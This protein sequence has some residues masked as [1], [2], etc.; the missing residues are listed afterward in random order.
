MTRRTD[1]KQAQAN[2]N[3]LVHNHH[4]IVKHGFEQQIYGQK[5]QTPAEEA[6]TKETLAFLEGLKKNGSP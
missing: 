1:Q 6:Q 2:G 3:R 4:G 5:Q